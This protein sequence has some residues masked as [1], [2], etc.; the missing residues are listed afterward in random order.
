MKRRSGAATYSSVAT[1]D[2]RQWSASGRF[3]AKIEERDDHVTPHLITDVFMHHF[4]ILPC[5]DQAVTLVPDVA[6]MTAVPVDD[7]IVVHLTH[8][9]L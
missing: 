1:P 5:R 7:V 3:R 8:L 2:L 6:D 9:P 4:D